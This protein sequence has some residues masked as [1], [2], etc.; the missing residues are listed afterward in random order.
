MSL[1]RVKPKC[2]FGRWHLFYA[3]DG[4]G[5]QEGDHVIEGGRGRGYPDK[6]SMCRD[7]RKS[8]ILVW[9]PGKAPK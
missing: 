1:R 8:Q 4:D 6:K 9:A 5:Y 2:V 7:V 3:E